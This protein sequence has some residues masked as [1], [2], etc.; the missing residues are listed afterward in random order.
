MGQAETPD[1]WR[2]ERPECCRDVDVST[3]DTVYGGDGDYR[4][5]DCGAAYQWNG[6][7]AGVPD[8]VTE[9]EDSNTLSEYTE[10][11]HSGGDE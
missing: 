10:T 5:P 9:T 7:M 3:L 8:L 4:C 6:E 11:S 1:Q 2:V